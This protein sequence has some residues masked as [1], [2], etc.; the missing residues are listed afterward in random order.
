MRF[1]NE[2]Q[3]RLRSF[4]SC[5]RLLR[6]SEW[7]L[8]IYLTYAAIVSLFLDISPAIRA[9][10]LVVNAARHRRLLFDRVSPGRKAS[11]GVGRGSRLAAVCPGAVV[12]SRDGLVR[13]G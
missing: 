5:F 9:Q 10:A 4:G 8:V 2:E 12:L 13:S 11:S 1:P 7:V 6:K 3:D